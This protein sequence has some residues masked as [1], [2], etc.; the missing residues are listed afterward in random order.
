[1]RIARAWTQ[2]KK[3]EER[4]CRSPTPLR[5][6][7]IETPPLSC[8]PSIAA[9]GPK[10]SDTRPVIGSSPVRWAF[11][12]AHQHPAGTSQGHQA[13]QAAPCAQVGRLH[14]LQLEVDPLSRGSVAG[15]TWRIHICTRALWSYLGG[16]DLCGN[17][18]PPFGCPA[19]SP[20]RFELPSVPSSSAPIPC[21]FSASQRITQ[22]PS[23]SQRFSMFRGNVNQ[24]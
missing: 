10:A 7:R 21:I 23:Q 13:A 3:Q 6:W 17:A 2:S 22:Q 1:M 19:A 5:V 11:G 18:L 9:G 24:P 4:R 14:R 15:R 16:N 20:L 12:S 8:P